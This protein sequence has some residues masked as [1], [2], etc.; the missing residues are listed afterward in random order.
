[1]RLSII[2][3]SLI[4]FDRRKQKLY[5]SAYNLL[6]VGMEETFFYSRN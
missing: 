4:I 2:P 1:M 3:Y 5:K 6:V